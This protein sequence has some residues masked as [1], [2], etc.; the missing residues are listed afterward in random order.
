MRARWQLE[1]GYF[2]RE[3]KVMAGDSNEA[4]GDVSIMLVTS[5]PGPSH[6]ARW[7]S[8][9]LS[10]NLLH[11]NGKPV[12]K[13]VQNPFLCSLVLLHYDLL[14]SSLFGAVAKNR[15]VNGVHVL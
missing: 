9:V 1:N 15:T 7:L 14:L 11:K 2:Q 10:E 3:L 8:S 5:I 13:L 12:S 4:C 6:D